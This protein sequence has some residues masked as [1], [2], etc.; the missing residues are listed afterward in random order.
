MTICRFRK[1][2][3]NSERACNIKWANSESPLEI[4]NSVVL[5]L[6]NNSWKITV[7]SVDWMNSLIVRSSTRRSLLSGQGLPNIWRLFFIE[8][9]RRRYF[10]NNSYLGKTK[11]LLIRSTCLQGFLE[12]NSCRSCW[13]FLTS[14][15]SMTVKNENYKWSS[16]ANL[17]VNFP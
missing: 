11:K 6:N 8:K 16:W 9:A 4:K 15:N 12:V 17:L 5:V 14:L 13:C 7:V 1:N 10:G 3:V 2:S